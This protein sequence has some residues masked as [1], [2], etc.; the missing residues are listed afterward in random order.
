MTWHAWDKPVI[1]ITTQKIYTHRHQNICIISIN[2]MIYVLRM[3]ESQLLEK[4]N[5]TEYLSVLYSI[6]YIVNA[7]QIYLITCTFRKIQTYLNVHM[8][9]FIT[10][11][12]THTRAR[13]M[14]ITHI[15]GIVYRYLNISYFWIYYSYILNSEWVYIHPNFLHILENMWV[16]IKLYFIY[17]CV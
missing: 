7:M 15:I 11:Y 6:F 3:H 1:N 5:K 14:Y 10:S 12:F 9:Y 17:I 13:N 4:Y 8:F 16:P 2:I